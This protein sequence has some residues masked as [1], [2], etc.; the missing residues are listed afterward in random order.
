MCPISSYDIT[1]LLFIQF[2]LQDVNKATPPLSAIIPVI[3]MSRTIQCKTETLAVS[4]APFKCFSR[5]DLL[6][7]MNCTKEK[8]ERDRSVFVGFKTSLSL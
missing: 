6:H 4:T 7:L 8:G 3:T 1:P 2:K 5:N